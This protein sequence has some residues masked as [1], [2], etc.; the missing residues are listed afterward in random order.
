MKRYYILLIIFLAITHG[1]QAQSKPAV[2]VGKMNPRQE[3]DIN[4]DTYIKDILQI[5]SIATTNSRVPLLGISQNNEIVKILTRSGNTTSFNF[6]TYSL[7]NIGGQGDNVTDFDT[8]IDTTDFVLSIAGY[9]FN[10]KITLTTDNKVP[11]LKIRL[12]P[13]GSTWHINL[14]YVGGSSAEGN[15]TWQI[16]ILAVNKIV[17]SMLSP[18][19]VDLG[20]RNSGSAP[21]PP[22]GI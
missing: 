2:G 5:D 1:L 17:A 10:K 21:G 13:S 3:L 16:S 15:G 8:G 4:G 11:P 19:S 18:V 12:F 22:S 14:D 6:L 7:S 9:T 20:G